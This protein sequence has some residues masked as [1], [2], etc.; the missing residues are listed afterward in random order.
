MG[1]ATVQ[2]GDVVIMTDDVPGARRG[3]ALEERQR[4]A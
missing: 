2:S 4:T 1:P 3:M